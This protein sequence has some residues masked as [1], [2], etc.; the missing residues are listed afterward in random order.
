[1]SLP[2][3]FSF[4]GLCLVIINFQMSGCA[5]VARGT[6]EAL[7]VKSE[8][9]GAKVTVMKMLITQEY[10]R[11][12]NEGLPPEKY[13]IEPE[14][15]LQRN[16][17]EKKSLETE[18]KYFEEPG[19]KELTGITP[20]SFKLVRRDQYLV[21]IEKDGYE[22]SKVVVNSQICSQG[23]QGMVGNICLGGCIGAGVDA[24]S[25]RMNELVPN[26]V[27]VK[28][29]SSNKEKEPSTELPVFDRLKQLK[30]LK[31]E[32]ILTEEEYEQKRK[33]LLDKL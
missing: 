1:M 12:Q 4:L 33:K 24:T 8:P 18:R 3:K 2:I 25:G 9:P 5:T 6:E 26:P 19:F 23:S 30:E 17:D 7:V 10:K 29:V 16:A 32:G 11:L 15:D 20:T 14:E 28:L 22:T 27:D 21:T 31:D 13:G